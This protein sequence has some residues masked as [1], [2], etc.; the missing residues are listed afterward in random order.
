MHVLFVHQAFPAQFGQ[1][2]VE[3][4]RT[5]GWRCS[6]L[7]ES[8][9]HCPP[10]SPEM[11]ER[12][13]IHRWSSP[14]NDST[15]LPWPHHF[16]AYLEQCQA[17]LQSL[18]S[19]PDLRPDLVV[20]HGG[21]G[22][23]SAFIGEAL[24][25]PVIVYCEYYFAQAHADLTFRLDLPPGDPEVES[26]FPRCINAPTLLALTSAKTGYAPTHWQKQSFPER[27]QSRIEVAFD[28]VDTSLYRPRRVT[29]PYTIAGRT[30]NGDTRLVSFAARGL[31][32]VRGYDLFL[33]LAARLVQERS[34]LLFVVAGADD[35][36][37][38]WDSL[39]IPGRS[40]ADWARE[41]SRIEETGLP[42]VHLGHVD[43]AVLADVL[44]LSDLHVYLSVP[45]VTSWS[46]FDAMACGAAVLAADITPVREL[47]EPGIHGIVTP[48]FDLEA[49]VAAS[50]KILDDPA[51]H[52]A[53]G[54]AARERITSSYSLDVCVPRLASFFERTAA[55]V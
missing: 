53:L 31:E 41:Q 46:L 7:V 13:E 19:R 44:S 17:V 21:R 49:Q 9:S 5:R 18:R 20:A 45:F 37:Y 55:G 36:H 34:D 32:S 43:P 2:A 54:T 25:C 4:A 1:L 3:L 12:V 10:P 22:A 15:P 50:L 26:L 52:A 42:I 27:F 23:P 51:G 30:I 6:V 11:L 48:L 33:K 16:G 47:I 8:M 24:D 28:G 35:V 38:G 14:R 29:R 39:R 40:F